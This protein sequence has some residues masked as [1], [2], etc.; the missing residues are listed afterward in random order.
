MRAGATDPRPPTRWDGLGRLCIL[1]GAV[2]AVGVVVPP[3]FGLAHRYEL[4]E[5]VQFSVLA[6]V[7][8]PLLAIGA[9]WSRPGPKR[10][11]PDGAP[12]G[13]G[14]PA[15]GHR[16]NRSQARSAICT[17]AFM[18]AAVAWR[19]P[20]A[21]GA[22][23]R[24]SFLLPLEAASLVVVGVAFWLDLVGSGSLVL[25]ASRPLRA[26]MAAVAMWTVWT[27][28]YLGG[29][30]G[31][32]WYTGFHHAAGGGLSAAADQQFATGVCWFFA[33]VAF[34]PVVFWNLLVWLRTEEEVEAGR[35]PHRPVATGSAPVEQSPVG[36]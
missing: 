31:A 24:R 23:E 15:D 17:A 32:S 5:A 26:L 30:S 20:G 10:R 11:P 25:R 27:V 1:A 3:L 18:A 21:V 2:L 13:A 12:S 28:A 16:R 14:A 36:S 8:P 22:L 4:A 35:D 7:V 19:T 33:A 9:S 34:M 6:M 29:F